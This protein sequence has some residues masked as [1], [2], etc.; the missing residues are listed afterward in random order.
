M[1][2][3]K[4]LHGVWTCLLATDREDGESQSWVDPRDADS[5]SWNQPVRDT[6]VEDTLS[7]TWILMSLRNCDFKSAIGSSLDALEKGVGEKTDH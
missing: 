2:V 3:P 4:H 1:K 7:Q 6:G 5:P